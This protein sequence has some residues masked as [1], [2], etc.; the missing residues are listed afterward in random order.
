MPR[1]KPNY[2]EGDWIALPLI[3][4]GGWGWLR[5]VNR[6]RSLATFLGLALQSRRRWLIRWDC[7]A[8][9]HLSALT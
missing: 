3:R 6:Q 8:K 5:G 7:V 2:K 1:R 9:T 4:R